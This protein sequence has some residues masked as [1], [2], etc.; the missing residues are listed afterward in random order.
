[1]LT[2]MRAYHSGCRPPPSPLLG[3]QGFF[4]P[5]VT[6][7]NNDNAD[8]L[9]TLKWYL[10]LFSCTL[11]WFEIVACTQ[12]TYLCF[13]AWY[14]IL[15]ILNCCRFQ[16]ACNPNNIYFLLSFVLITCIWIHVFRLPFNSQSSQVSLLSWF[17]SLIAE[18]FEVG[19][20]KSSVN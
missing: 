12:T 5:N 11:K 18:V 19:I 3:T 9:I 16:M 2:P 6:K 10:M 15:I 14:Y 1:M 7:T 8:L 20:K 4:P 13:D 17:L